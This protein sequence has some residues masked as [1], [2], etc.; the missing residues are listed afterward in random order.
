MHG[1]GNELN[2]PVAIV[3]I[4]MKEEYHIYMLNLYE[5]LYH[6]YTVLTAKM[7]NSFSNK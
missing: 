6:Y 4:S 3:G 7:N 5:A 1:Y 2:F